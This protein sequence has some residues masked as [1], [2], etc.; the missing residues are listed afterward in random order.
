MVVYGTLRQRE[1]DQGIQ[2]GEFVVAEGRLLVVF[3]ALS[4]AVGV[5]TLALVV[6]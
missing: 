3:T 1:V 4:V 5:A 2:R 6:I